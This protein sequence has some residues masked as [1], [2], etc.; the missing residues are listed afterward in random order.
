MQATSSTMRQQQ[1]GLCLRLP[2][3]S[4]ATLAVAKADARKAKKALLAQAKQEAEAAKASIAAAKRKSLQEEQ[5]ER[6]LADLLDE[7]AE[8]T[9]STIGRSSR[10]QKRSA[11]KVR[12]SQCQCCT[13][14]KPKH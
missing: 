9:T 1:D 11:S 2:P 12:D 7:S 8:E 10:R 6:V 4:K 13:T 3:N 5:A 14:R